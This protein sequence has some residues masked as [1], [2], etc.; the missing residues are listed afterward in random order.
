[1]FAISR[2]SDREKAS[3]TLGADGVVLIPRTPPRQQRYKSLSLLLLNLGCVLGISMVATPARSADRV[4]LFVGPLEFSLAVESLQRYADNGNVQPDLAP[5]INRL[6]DEQQEQLR[7]ILGTRAEVTPVAISQFL[8]TPQ[9]EII[10]REL[11]TLIQTRSGQSGFYAIRS[12]LILAAA[13]KEGLTPLNVLRKF[14]TTSIRI[15]SAR[16]FELIGRVSSLVRQTEGAISA[17]R[18]EALTEIGNDSSEFPLDLQQAGSI[19]FTQQSLILNDV[20]RNRTFPIDFYLPQQGTSVPLIVISHG[21]GSNRDSYRYLALHLASH[22]FAVAVPEH[23]GSNAAQLQALANGL[24]K[25]I[26][27]PRELLDRPLDVKFLLDEL[28]RQ[29]PQQIDWQRVGVVGQSFGGYTALALAGAQLN[30]EELQSNCDPNS[31]DFNISF[32][33]QCQALRLPEPNYNLSDSRIKAAIAIN[34][35]SSQIFGPQQLASLKTPIML[36][37]GSADAVTPA[38]EEQI[39]PFTTLTTPDKYLVLLEN[40]THFS[41]IGTTDEDIAL[42]PQVLGPDPAIAY[43]YTKAMALAFFQTYVA[44]NA[45]YSP[46]LSAAYAQSISRWPIPLSFIKSLSLEQLQSSMQETHLTVK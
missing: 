16:V 11:G 41:T 27:P 26:T 13:D 12:A 7:K 44:G 29:Y 25:D 31:L 37:S 36:I 24:V 2:Q 43:D 39:R 1:M 6:N 35:L 38:L 17:I 20:A 4:S 22:G 28:Q 45:Q 40:G 14:P 42:P 32:L 46:Y 21:L 8:Y 10:L 19:P 9:G 33:L 34:P 18:Q 23:P 3:L 30:T 15:N 5:Y